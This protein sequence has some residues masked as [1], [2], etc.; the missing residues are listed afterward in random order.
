MTVA[1][2]QDDRGRAKGFRATRVVH[3]GCKDWE[4]VVCEGIEP[5]EDVVLALDSKVDEVVKDVME[6]EG[7][8]AYPKLEI[9]GC[10]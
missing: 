8:G 1:V 10:G 4:I 6:Y 2:T 9:Q 5:S 3:H 7:V